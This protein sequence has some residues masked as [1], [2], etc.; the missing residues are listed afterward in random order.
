M[1]AK[2]DFA[3]QLVYKAGQ[4]IKSEMQNTFD[5]EEKSRFDDLV[6]SLDKKTQKL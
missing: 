5:V 2:F 6:T 4:F 3:K 1:D